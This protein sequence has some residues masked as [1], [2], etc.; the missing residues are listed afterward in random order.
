MEDVTLVSSK[1]TRN[2]CLTPPVLLPSILWILDT[3][4]EDAEFAQME[5]QNSESK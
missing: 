4:A 3:T 2:F 5:T 1:S